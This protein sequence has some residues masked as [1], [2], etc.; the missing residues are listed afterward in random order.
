MLSHIIKHGAKKDVN[1]NKTLTLSFDNIQ[2]AVN[3]NTNKMQT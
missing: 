1:L 3:K 2:H